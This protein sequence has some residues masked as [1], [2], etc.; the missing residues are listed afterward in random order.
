MQEAIPAIKYAQQ[1]HK[2]PCHG[3]GLRSCQDQNRGGRGVTRTHGVGAAS[4]SPATT[5]A[6]VVNAI[7]AAT[8]TTTPPH[9]TSTGSYHYN[10][11][12]DN[13]SG[14]TSTAATVAS[15]AYAWQ[16]HLAASSFQCGRFG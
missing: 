6:T 14:T 16:W 7:S 3:Q 13:V 2:D 9:R 4:S 15:T 8:A 10:A 5:T 11:S 1:S 12:I